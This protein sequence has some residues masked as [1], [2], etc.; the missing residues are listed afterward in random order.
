MWSAAGLDRTRSMFDGWNPAGLSVAATKAT[1]DD[2]NARRPAGMA[3][4]T[5]HHRAFVQ[6]PHART[7]DGD[8]VARLADEAAEAAAHGFD[9]FI[10]EH[11]FWSGVED[12]A[13]WVD[14]PERFAPVVAAAAG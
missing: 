4:L 14:V 6:F 3:P 12:P 7:P 9:D 2:L 8:P 11:N 13:A 1:L 5:M 10:V